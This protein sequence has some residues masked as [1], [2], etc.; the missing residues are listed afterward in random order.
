MA[1]FP[2]HADYVLDPSRDLINYDLN[3]YCPEESWEKGDLTHW[4]MAFRDRDHNN[5]M[6]VDLHELAFTIPEDFCRAIGLVQ[7]AESDTEVLDDWLDSGLDGWIYLDAFL[8][9]YASAIT[10]RLARKLAKLPEYREELDAC[11]K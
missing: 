6:D 7:F 4:R 3:I 11:T 1:K 10:P 9:L 5:F 8:E 2:K